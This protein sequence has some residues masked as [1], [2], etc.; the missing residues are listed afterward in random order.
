MSHW[1]HGVQ[2]RAGEKVIR[3]WVRGAEGQSLLAPKSSEEGCAFRVEFRE[4]FADE[5]VSFVEFGSL[6]DL[7]G[8][9]PMRSGTEPCEVSEEE[10]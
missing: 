2:F 9:R 7:L 5:W 10:A 4:H 1:M 8:G 3:F 6:L